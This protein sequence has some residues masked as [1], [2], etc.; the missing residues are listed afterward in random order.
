MCNEIQGDV[1]ICEEIGGRAFLL[2]GTC[3]FP[4]SL[5][6]VIPESANGRVA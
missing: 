1:P 2:V 5:A 4:D 3:L 6:G